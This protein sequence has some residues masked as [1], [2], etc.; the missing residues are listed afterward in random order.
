M[1]DL[2]T[3]SSEESY[4]IFDKQRFIH[5]GNTSLGLN[6]TLYITPEEEAFRIEGIV[7]DVEEN[8]IANATVNVYK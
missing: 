4:Y 7:T 8:I 5:E 3:C 2:T 1:F 6:G